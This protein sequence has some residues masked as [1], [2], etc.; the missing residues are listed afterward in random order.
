MPTPTRLFFLTK[1]DFF[2]RFH[3][4]VRSW[5]EY[6]GL[7]PIGDDFIE[8]FLAT[9]WVLHTAQLQY[10]PRYTKQLVVRL[11]AWLPRSCIIHHA[12]HEAYKFTLFCPCLYFQ[13]AYNTWSDK[14]LFEP[15]SGTV[16]EAMSEVSLCCL[17]G[18]S[19]ST[20]GEFERMR[21]YQLGSSF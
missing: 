21:N 16:Q 9:H 19:P 7:P 17:Q 12:D 3:A 8:D 5:S 4:Q 14:D 10:A 18:C 2:T 11:K 20:D 13:G 15:F 1:K 6:H